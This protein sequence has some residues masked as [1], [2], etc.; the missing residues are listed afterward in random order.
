[1]FT[2]LMNGRIT[3]VFGPLY[4]VRGHMITINQLDYSI[5]S[6]K[7]QGSVLTLYARPGEGSTWTH[8]GLDNLWQ[9]DTQ[10]LNAKTLSRPETVT[11]IQALGTVTSRTRLSMTTSCPMDLKMYPMD[12][13]MCQ[14]IFQSSAHA[15]DE[16]TY[17]WLNNP[18]LT[19]VQGLEAQ[20]KMTPDFKLLG[21]KLE[22]LDKVDELSGKNFTQLIVKLYLE[23]PV[24]YFIWEV[25]MPASFIVFMSFTSFWLD[26]TATPARVSLGV[27]ST[28]TMTTLLSSSNNNLPPTAY[29][30]VI[31]LLFNIFS[32]R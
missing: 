3:D 2:S 25:Y 20:D 6:I 5:V 1:M 30:K 23:R 21:Y 12:R 7:G 24:G 29:P 9:P 31:R 10:V 8:A 28:L 16:L 27:T 18:K 13:Q 11:H 15:S 19:F 26:R 32:H 14:I 17:I 4:R 22:R